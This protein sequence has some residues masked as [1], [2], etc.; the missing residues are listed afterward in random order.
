M[1]R[2][3]EPEVSVLAMDGESEAVASIEQTEPVEKLSFAGVLYDLTSSVVYAMLFVCILFTFFFRM[4]SVDGESMENTLHDR[5]WLAISS[6]LSAPERGDIVIISR[7]ETNERPLVKR[8]IAVGGDEIDIDF[9]THIVRVNGEVQ[10]EPYI[11]E[12][13]AYKGDLD[14]PLTVPDGHVF[15][16]GDNRNE[17]YDS[18]FSAV[19]FVDVNKI[20]GKK[21]IRIFPLA[22]SDLF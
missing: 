1:L 9:V 17:S 13:T 6:F 3:K 2:K 20:L 15:V 22:T 16:M 21:A 19:G 11:K 8:V 7:E 18:R 4:V 10:N 14:F 12:P 5:D